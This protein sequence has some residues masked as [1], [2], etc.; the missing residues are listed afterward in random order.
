MRP[1]VRSFLAVI[2]GAVVA[3]ALVA[4]IE[5]AGHA[6]Y[7][8]P[9][10]VEFSDPQALAA[11]VQAMPLGAWLFVLAAWVL[12]ALGGG[13]AA[14]LIARRRLREHAAVVGAL[15]LAA[16]VA[17]LLMVAHPA[18]FNVAGVAGV[19]LATLASAR[20]AEWLLRR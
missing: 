1:A 5:A 12:A 13:V 11:Y 18:W 20:I 3:F 7:P 8:V 14:G 10:D 15:V 19:V 2:A 9:A 17:N 6:A 4:A 16:T